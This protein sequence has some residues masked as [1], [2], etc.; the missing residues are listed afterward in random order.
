MFATLFELM[1][2]MALLVVS[3]FVLRKSGIITKEGKKCLTDIILYA[4]LP[5]N[6]IK[7]FSVEMEEGFWTDFAQVLIIA[8]LIQVGA[9][10]ISKTMYNRM[11]A[12]EKQVFQYATV[13]S[14]SGF[15]GNPLAEGI[16]GNTGLLYASIFLIPQRIVMW[17]AGV[18][19]FQS[20]VDK[21][22]VYK[23]V[24]T[25]PCMIATYMGL[26]IMIFQITLPTVIADT[27][28]SFSN[29]CTAMTMMYVGT[30]LVDVDFKTLIELKQVCFAGVR[31]VLIPM[32]VFVGCLIAGVDPLVAGVCTLLSGTPAGATT[33]LLASKYGADEISAAKCVVLTTALSMITIPLWSAV[34]ISRI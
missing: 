29:C 1:G 12:G 11:K 5:C 7:A 32:L 2:M 22:N 13:C 20:G 23:K 8:I 4:I 15:M 28:K 16:F 17:T 6:I 18:S 19:Y 31:L 9:L 25:H 14:N 34:L 30:I 24:L 27:V 26:I 10:I 3:G 33:S 21:K